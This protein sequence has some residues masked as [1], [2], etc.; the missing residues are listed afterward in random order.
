MLGGE[1][2]RL[3]NLMQRQQKQVK[4]QEKKEKNFDFGNANEDQSP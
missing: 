2:A 1:G 4:P 3:G